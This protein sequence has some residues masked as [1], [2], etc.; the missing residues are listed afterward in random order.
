MKE[1]KPVPQDF[2]RL[3]K[4]LNHTKCAEHYKVSR[5][6]IWRWE[7]ETGFHC[8]TKPVRIKRFAERDKNILDLYM[9]AV[10]S[11]AEIAKLYNMSK[12]RI[13]QIV[14]KEGNKL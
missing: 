8:Q 13:W 9:N 3:A 1:K 4:N 11:L 10:M 12:S 6:V 2:C 5:G 14:I 7:R